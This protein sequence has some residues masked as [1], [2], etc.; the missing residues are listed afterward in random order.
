[1]TYSMAFFWP[2]CS[3]A[4]FVQWPFCSEVFFCSVAFLVPWPF[5][6]VAFLFRG[7]FVPWL[8]V[9]WPF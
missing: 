9:P 8:F 2:F 3:V 1:V 4:Y 5:C 7:L 6:S